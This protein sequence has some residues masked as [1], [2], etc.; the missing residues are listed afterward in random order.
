MSAASS[1]WNNAHVQSVVVP[2][3]GSKA[4]LV[5]SHPSGAWWESVVERMG[6][7]TA[8]QRGWDGYGAGPVSF[9]SA[10]FALNMLQSLC[11]DLEAEPQIVPGSS[12][13]LQIEWHEMA[14]SIELHVLAPNHVHAWRR[15]NSDGLEEDL[16]LRSDFS[17]VIPW[18][19][20]LTGPPVAA[21]AAAN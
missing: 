14:A 15:R 6:A 16:V 7:L 13:D 1:S 19:S 4:R 3:R 12:G 17:Q 10:Y 9:E 18:I 8:L 11:A 2:F 21:V 5:V 20:E